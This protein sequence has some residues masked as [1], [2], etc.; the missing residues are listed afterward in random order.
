MARGSTAQKRARRKN[1]RRARR[2][3]RGPGK[4]K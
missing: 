3:R 4:R 1:L 2:R